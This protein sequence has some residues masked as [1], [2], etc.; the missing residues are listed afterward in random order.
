MDRKE[1]VLKVCEVFSE[2]TSREGRLK[3]REGEK[4]VMVKEQ[5]FICINPNLLLI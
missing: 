4:R 2:T 5:F 3:R 1:S